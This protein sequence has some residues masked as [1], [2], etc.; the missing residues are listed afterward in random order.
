M[1][2]VGFGVLRLRV[3]LMIYA[4]GFWVCCFWVLTVVCCALIFHFFLVWALGVLGVLHV[5]WWVVLVWFLDGVVWFFCFV[6]VCFDYVW[7]GVRFTVYLVVTLV[8]LFWNYLCAWFVSG[9][10]GLFSGCV[11]GFRLVVYAGLFV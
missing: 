11:W 4:C 5:G 6:L 10:T 7:I 9:E 2:Y 1:L 3:V 8:D